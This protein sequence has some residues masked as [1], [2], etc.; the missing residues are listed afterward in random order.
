MSIAGAEMLSAADAT[1][2]QPFMD[3]DPP[4]FSV[5]EMGTAR[6]ARDPKTSA[7]NS[8]NQCHDI[9]N[10]FIT[11]GGCMASSGCVNPS[12]TYVTLTARACD[13]A[14]NLMKRGEL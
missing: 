14:V 13:H 5:H 12:L 9:K 1:S 7:L 3:D 11:D 2:I 8:W 6:I 10:L 4:G